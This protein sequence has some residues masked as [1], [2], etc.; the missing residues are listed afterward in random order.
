[1]D[2]DRTP[3]LFEPFKQESEGLDREYGGSGLGRSIVKRLTEA[4]GGT[5]DVETEKR[6]GTSILVRL[7]IRPIST[8]DAE[9][10]HE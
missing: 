6:E 8:S 7:P 5:L 3:E 4:L 2:R 9:R 10:P 1:M